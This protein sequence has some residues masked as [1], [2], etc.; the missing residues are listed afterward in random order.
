MGRGTTRGSLEFTLE[1]DHPRFPYFL[2]LSR[3]LDEV[4]DRLRRFSDA[5]AVPFLVDEAVPGRRG[6]TL[7]IPPERAA[8]LYSRWERA[9]KPRFDPDDQVIP[10]AVVPSLTMSLSAAAE[11]KATLIVTWEPEPWKAVIGDTGALRR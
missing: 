10:L 7:S 11:S 6:W 1:P 2:S 5:L 8:D 4:V 3:G 9:G